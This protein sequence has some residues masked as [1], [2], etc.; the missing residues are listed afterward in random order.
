[1]EMRQEKIVGT[2]R[3]LSGIPE[4]TFRFWVMQTIAMA[5]GEI[6]AHGVAAAGSYRLAIVCV[7]SIAILFAI[8]RVSH[9]TFW[10]AMVAVTI[11][12]A[13]L[14]HTTDRSLGI[15]DFVASVQLA[16]LLAVSLIVWFRTTGTIAI[17]SI[18]SIRDSVLVWIVVMLAQTYASALADWA[19]DPGQTGS[20]IVPVAIV[21]GLP[22]VA[23]AFRWARISHP[24]LFWTAFVLTGILG[25]LC[26]DLLVRLLGNSDLLLIA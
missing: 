13:M 22:A 19:I 3:Y 21:L 7:A 15:G 10:L 17:C 26:G 23:V 9:T 11:V 5:L 4:I 14:A 1:M 12:S 18:G 20:A 25:A 2:T 8:D 6:G 16:A 24:A